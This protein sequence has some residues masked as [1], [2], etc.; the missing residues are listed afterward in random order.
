MLSIVAV[1]YKT[2]YYRKLLISDKRD[3][4]RK[5]DARKIIISNRLKWKYISNSDGPIVDNK[6]KGQIAKR[7]F[8]KNK[9]RQIFRK[10]N[11]SYPLIRTRT[12]AY[13][14]VRNIHFLENW[15]CF[16]FLKQLFW[17]SP[18]CLITDVI[19]IYRQNGLL[20]CPVYIMS[21]STVIVSTFLLAWIRDW[22]MYC[23]YLDI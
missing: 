18:F 8:Q 20:M 23:R 6:A 11:I 17:D 19:V 9:A 13:Q 1:I 12:C 21:K 5:R 4:S 2:I 7:V 16:I 22:K 10:A 15:A 14:W 3:V